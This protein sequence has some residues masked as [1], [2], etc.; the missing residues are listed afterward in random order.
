MTPAAGVSPLD[1]AEIERRQILEAEKAAVEEQ[2]G[3]EW[4]MKQRQDA[5]RKLF[6][7]SGGKVML[8]DCS[9]FDA[10]KNVWA[11]GNAD[12]E[13]QVLGL[14]KLKVNNG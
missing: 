4:E 11:S 1:E 10:D 7:E 13:H 8:V 14:G 5:A 6:A 12:F 9:P 3:L 2:V